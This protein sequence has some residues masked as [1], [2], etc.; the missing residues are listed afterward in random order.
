MNKRRT[1][2]VGIAGAAMLI[3]IFYVYRNRPPRYNW[4]ESYFIESKEPYGGFVT[5]ELLRTYFPQKSF[6]VSKKPLNEFFDKHKY[7]EPA[8]Y[9]FIGTTFPSD[10]DQL[11]SLL[12]FVS[13]GNTAFIASGSCPAELLENFFTDSCAGEYMYFEDR[14]D[15]SV[16]MRLYSASFR[17]LK[18]VKLNYLFRNIP[19]TYSWSY[20]DSTFFCAESPQ[21][22]VL[23]E[24]NAGQFNFL[25]ARYG[26]GSFYI[27]TTPLALSNLA[28]K[29]P[30]N[31]EYASNL[32]SWLQPGDIIWDAYN[33]HEGN[34]RFNSDLNL[35][36]SPLGYILSQDSLRW[37][38]YMVI[39][40]TIL[41]MI[42][43]GK[44]Q[45]RVIPV[46][47]QNKNTSLEYIRT[48][49]QLYYQERNHKVICMHKMKLF[50]A[51]LRNRY[52]IN[53]HAAGD[54]VIRKI[55][56]KSKVHVDTVR[57]IFS[58]YSWID[59]NPETTD[60]MLIDFHQQIENFYKTCK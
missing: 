2:I 19:Y 49:G 59:K 28:M 35:S 7:T 26:T 6:S 5:G 50:L 1:W 20:F 46:L 57:E 43:F 25:R 42:F 3:L 21:Q 14:H 23:G 47:E 34:L 18:S 37:A 12:E 60:Q 30:E 54:E 33:Q 29:N 39:A 9:I 41:Y 44:R 45:Q 52:F 58:Q 17:N 8:N 40:M 22:E 48:V 10:P 27:Y 16:N 55:S 15:S 4:Y 56:D 32:F 24:M 11:H 38:W 51:F 31:A 13:V 36:Q 53:A